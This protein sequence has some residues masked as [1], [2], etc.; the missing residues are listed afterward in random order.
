[1]LSHFI[2]AISIMKSRQQLM[3][4]AMAQPVVKSPRASQVFA[5]AAAKAGVPRV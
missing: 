1:V 3:R 2:G 4:Q 5:A